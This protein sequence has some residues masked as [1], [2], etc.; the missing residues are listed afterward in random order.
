VLNFPG[1]RA[2]LR[3]DCAT[4]GP[5]GATTTET[6]Y[7]ATSLDPARVSAAAL[8]RLVRGHW[9]VEN[10]LH[11]VK[12]RWWD[13]DRHVC[14]RPGL[15]AGFTSLVTAALTVLRAT[16]PGGEGVPL[17]AQADDLNRDVAAAIRLMVG[18]TL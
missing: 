13:E 10:G 6:R 15:A 8:L 3:V 2:L 16:S 5:G 14:R 11:F 17:R 1:L 18:P 12:D 7:F 9:Q 4:R